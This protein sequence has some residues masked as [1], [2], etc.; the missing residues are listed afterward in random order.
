MT[1]VFWININDEQPKDG[2]S[3]FYLDVKTSEWYE[4]KGYQIGHDDIDKGIYLKDNF[5]EWH[6]DCPCEEFKYWYPIP[7]GLK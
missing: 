7:K 6:Y 2:Q 3:I 1:E 5:V 4:K